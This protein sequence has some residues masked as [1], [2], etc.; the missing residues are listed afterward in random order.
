[1]AITD[2]AELVGDLADRDVPRNFLE[3]T[4]HAPT[5]WRR[6]P[7]A[8]VLIVI[9]PVRLLARVALRRWMALVTAELHQMT[10]LEL[11]LETTIAFA[12]DA[13]GRFPLCH[14]VRVAHSRLR[15]TPPTPTRHE[16]SFAKSPLL[17]VRS[18]P[19]QRS[20][21]PR[22][23]PRLGA[24]VVFGQRQLATE[25]VLDGELRP[26]PHVR[27]RI[28]EAE[29]QPRQL[30]FAERRPRVRVGSEQPERGL[31][32]REPDLTDRR[33]EPSVYA[34]VQSVIGS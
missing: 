12:Q 6:Q 13:R 2:R 21:L 16:E 19:P 34:L 30:E 8:V 14:P 28:G 32:A 29:V 11:D 25:H 26:H 33:V 20:D 31:G 18:S 7:I 5:Q 15:P 10:T 4:I 1:M 24:R 27:E 23:Y 3:R 22:S 17:A 9:E